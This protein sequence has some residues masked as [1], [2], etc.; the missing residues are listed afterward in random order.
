MQFAF[1]AAS[2]TGNRACLQHRAGDVCI[3]FGMTRQYAAGRHA[4][5]VT[6]EVCANAFN[7]VRDPFFAKVSVRARRAGLSALYAGFDTSDQLG[8][9]DTTE[10][11][12]VG[13][14]HAAHGA[15][16]TLL[17][18]AFTH[19]N[20]LLRTSVNAHT[21][22]AGVSNVLGEMASARLLR[23]IRTVF[24]PAY[25]GRRHWDPDRHRRLVGEHLV[26]GDFGLAAFGQL[27]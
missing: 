21:P 19:V 23:V 8:R 3:V 9:V 16:R 22:A 27:G 20:S 6:V 24:V 18:V 17:H 13:L 5:V 11:P 25:P 12:G 2:L 4:H 1:V 26:V 7:E 15:H 14:Q 10:P